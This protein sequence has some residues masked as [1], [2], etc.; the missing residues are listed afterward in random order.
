MAIANVNPGDLIKAADW[1]A[2]ITFLNA[3]DVRLTNLENNGTTGGGDKNPHITQ[4]LPEGPVTA[5][6]TIRI[7]GSNFDFTMGGQSV[8][9]GSTRAISFVTGSSDTLLIVQIPD[10]VA[11]A[12][13]AGAPLIMTVGNLVS[14]ATWPMTIKSKPVVTAGGF[15]FAYQGSTPGT[16]L[17][18]SPIIYHFQLRSFASEDLVTTITPVAHVIPPLPAGVTTT[19]AQLL[20]LIKVLDTDM[21]E[22]PTRQINLPEGATKL[23]HLQLSLPNSTDQLRYSLSA[24]ASAPGVTSVVESL[25]EQQVGHASEQP[26]PTISNLE[27]FSVS[28]GSTFSPTAPSGLDGT[29]SIPLNAAVTLR[30]RA[31]FV[32]IPATETHHYDCAVSVDTPANGWAAVRRPSM[33]NPLEIA[34]PGGL[35]DVFANITAPG[36]A[37]NA[38][39]RVVLTH[40]EATTSNKRTVAYRLQ[41]I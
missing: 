12:T 31:Q 40:A 36:T 6:D 21:S 34:S 27:F 16:P 25:P 17:Q 30:L 11:G 41:T 20:S 39:L 24:T 10:P 29:L 3:M 19:D 2:L 8:F 26:D 9:F 32:D 15:Q 35:K 7:F 38:V 37:T 13:E 33:L 14:T 23:I 22:R 5:G 28:G 18:N 4:V 1:N